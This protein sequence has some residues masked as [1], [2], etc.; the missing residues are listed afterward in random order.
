MI[1]KIV[2]PLDHHD[3]AEDAVLHGA[4]LAR[5]AGARLQLMSVR[6]SYV[7]AAATHDRLVEIAD[8]LRVDAELV[9]VGP[10]DVTATLAE[11]AAEP[12]TVLCLRTHAR[13]P[14]AE[15]TLGSVS[16]QVVRTTHH[17]VLLVGPHCD[18]APER[19]GS[20]VVG[21]D[22]SPLAEQ[23]LPVVTAWSTQL[24]LTPWLFQALSPR[25]PLEVGDD[26]TESGYVRNIAAQLADQQVKAE[27][28]TAHDRD[29]A[30]AVV[31]FA[32][33]LPTALIALT[34]HGRSGLGRIA[35]GGTAFRVAHR[36]HSPVLVLR[37]ARRGIGTT[38]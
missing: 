11:V 10:D 27:W 3:E 32:D 14:I 20:M 2:V 38:E 13:G 7:D 34:T 8:R 29:A 26:V 21:L 23:I 33:Q 4:A 35:L 9:V 16:E 22:G 25:V 36:A 12:G 31:S 5:Q 28:E 1:T 37:P 6:P 18:P 17:P 30:T 15:M 24:D 19:Y